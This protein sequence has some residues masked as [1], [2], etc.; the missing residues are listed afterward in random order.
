MEQ[1]TFNAFVKKY[2]IDLQ[3]LNHLKKEC[4][5]VFA[6]KMATEID[7]KIEYV[8]GDFSLQK[9]FLQK[10]IRRGELENI[11][12]LMLEVLLFTF[13]K[14]IDIRLNHKDKMR[15][16]SAL[17]GNITNFVNRILVSIVE[18][19]SAGDLFL[20]SDVTLYLNCLKN[21][22][23]YT[24]PEN[25]EMSL[26]YMWIVSQRICNVEFRVRLPSFL[27]ATCF[28]LMRMR[29]QSYEDESVFAMRKFFDDHEKLNM[30]QTLKQGG[31][32]NVLFLCM[33]NMFQT[34]YS[35]KT[36]VLKKKKEKQ[37]Y[38]LNAKDTK[39][40]IEKTMNKIYRFVV[41]K[42]KSSV[43]GKNAKIVS[44][45]IK[46]LETLKTHCLE[47][48]LNVKFS[49]AP[50]MNG[51]DESFEFGE[52]WV[53]LAH[54]MICCL[55]FD[56]NEMIEK[57]HNKNE[58]MDSVKQGELENIVKTHLQR[59]CVIVPAYCF[60]QHA[61][62][63]VRTEKLKRQS[64]NQYF[65]DEASFVKDEKLNFYPSVAMAKK[66]YQGISKCGYKRNIFVVKG[67]EK[68]R[69]RDKIEDDDLFNDSFLETI[70]PL[71]KK[72]KK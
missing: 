18:D 37:V 71:N 27:R 40:F 4:L 34:L 55:V 3:K 56:G 69:I 43:D 61:K 48:A 33:S 2:N 5:G 19:I 14:I 24:K 23:W 20:I 39:N 13:V 63:T 38:S 30:D 53:F 36:V 7:S 59:E 26:K 60:D 16:A 11:R 29:K 50:K 28:D 54:F 72:L 32:V 68:K 52:F 67:I 62:T 35:D 6:F 57:F 41:E 51:K 25:L 12:T 15:S 10:S 70:E 22:K 42:L 17:K 45:L 58:L 1:N 64:N 47:L 31:K 66:I 49:L 65:I 46:T 44:D 9:S 8:N 21:D